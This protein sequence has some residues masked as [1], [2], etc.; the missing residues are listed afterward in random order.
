MYEFHYK[1]S[2]TTLD[3][4]SSLKQKQIHRVVWMGPS[5]TTMASRGWWERL[6]LFSLPV[7]FVVHGTSGV[8]NHMRYIWLYSWTTFYSTRHRKETK[9]L[10]FFSATVLLLSLSDEMAAAVTMFGSH[11][12]LRAEFNVSKRS[13]RVEGNLNNCIILSYLDK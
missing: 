5:C 8:L 11:K 2:K 10:L 9:E 4:P 3:S 1:R 12:S 7:V 6:F 13:V